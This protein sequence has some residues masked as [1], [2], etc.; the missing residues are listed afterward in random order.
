V[1]PSWKEDTRSERVLVVVEEE[2]VKEVWRK[3]SK[4]QSLTE[5]KLEN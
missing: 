2:E 1:C 4:N 5:V 3:K